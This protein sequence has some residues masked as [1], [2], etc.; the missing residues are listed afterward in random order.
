MVKVF[1]DANIL[2]DILEKRRNLSL[3]KFD[4]QEMYASTLSVHIL[5]YVGNRKVAS[6][7]VSEMLLDLNLVNFTNNTTQKALL[8]P[9]ND[10]EDNVQLHSA[11]D[12]ECD[13]FLTEDKKL[14]DMKFFGKT[15]ITSWGESKIV[16]GRM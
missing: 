9:T 4:E 2:V 11:A 7:L 6:H 14:L 10:F 3:D 16:L 13:I 15:R 8:G 12:A 5:F 1:L